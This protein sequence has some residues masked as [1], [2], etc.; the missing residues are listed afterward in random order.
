MRLICVLI[1]LTSLAAQLQPP[2]AA[3]KNWAE[4]QGSV[5]DDKGQPVEGAKVYWV[6][7]NGSPIGHPE[8]VPTDKNGAFRLERVPP[9][10]IQIRAYKEEDFYN[11]PTFAF[12]DPPAS[13]M[14]EV[15][16]KVGRMERGVVLRLGPKAALLRISVV[17]ALSKEPLKGIDYQLCRADHANEVG[18]CITGSGS[19]SPG[20]EFRKL[21]PPVPV[22]IK[23]GA[24][25]YA[26]WS[27]RDGKTGFS[28]LRLSPG[29]TQMLTVHLQ[30]KPRAAN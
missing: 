16:A 28:F 3:N 7:L 20:G 22:S 23:I 12:Y 30:P 11:R 14:P 27:Y 19:L 26:E 5:V 21:V 24:A 6:A 17:D 1:L 15:E 13:A 25:N 4:V 2:G 10:K 18:Y 9:G 8:T 29:E